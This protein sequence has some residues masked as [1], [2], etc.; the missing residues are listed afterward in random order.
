MDKEEMTFAGGRS[1]FGR[2]PVIEEQPP[3][4]RFEQVKK[5]LAGLLIA[6]AILA[7]GGYIALSPVLQRLFN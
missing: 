5:Y 1:E 7:V 4:S 6:A 2:V 3:V